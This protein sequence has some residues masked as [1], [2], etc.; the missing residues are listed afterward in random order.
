MTHTK[1]S[2]SILNKCSINKA[3]CAPAYSRPN[4]SVVPTAVGVNPFLAISA[5]AE[6]IAEEMMK[7]N[8][9]QPAAWRSSVHVEIRGLP[10]SSEIQAIR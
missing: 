3:G 6:L 4:A 8:G 2:P 5:P 9:G 7:R 1:N 10:L